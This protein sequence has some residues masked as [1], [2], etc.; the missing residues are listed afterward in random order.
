MVSARFLTRLEPWPG[1]GSSAPKS[2]AVAL[3]SAAAICTL[4]RLSLTV[5]RVLASFEFMLPASAPM[6]VPIPP[7]RRPARLAP[8]PPALLFVS[9]IDGL[10]A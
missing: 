6:A 5:S 3:P 8:A 10:I 1:L 9:V 2:I 4:E 7:G